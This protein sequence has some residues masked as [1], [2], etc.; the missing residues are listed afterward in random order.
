MEIQ[1]SKEAKDYMMSFK[2]KGESFFIAYDKT[3]C[4][5][6]EEGIFSLRLVTH[7]DSNWV[8]VETIVGPIYMTKQTEMYLDQTMMIEY[9][10]TYNDLVLKGK[11]E[12]VMAGHFVIQNED[13]SQRHK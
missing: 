13:G 2:K 1:I 9:Q 4:T 3:G 5:C 11:Y 6:S 10:S 8:K 7:I 12:G